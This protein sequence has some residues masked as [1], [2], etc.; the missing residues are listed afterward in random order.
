MINQNPADELK[1]QIELGNALARLEV[2]P[3][4]QRVIFNGFIH[5]QL[6]VESMYLMST[7]PATRNEALE[8]I[9][10][11]NYLRDYFSKVKNIADGSRDEVGEE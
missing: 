4:F 10:A 9:Q 1:D 3:D 8:R 6:L 2:N 5:T 7:E 11:A